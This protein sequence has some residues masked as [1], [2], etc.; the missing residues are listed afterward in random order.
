MCCV[1]Y[2]GGRRDGGGSPDCERGL[3]EPAKKGLEK[4]SW[5]VMDQFIGGVP[6]RTA[7]V[8]QSQGGYISIYVLQMYY[9]NSNVFIVLRGIAV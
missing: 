5:S 2:R 9:F 1:R 7:L 4:L 8:I 3:I 6:A